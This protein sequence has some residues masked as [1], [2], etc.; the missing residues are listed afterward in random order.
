ME[1]GKRREGDTPK[2]AEDK[3]RQEGADYMV[4]EVGA[5]SIA[6]LQE[7]AIEAL[8]DIGPVCNWPMKKDTSLANHFNFCSIPPGLYERTLLFT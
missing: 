7:V 8:S 3:E 1:R 2:G 4:R 5:I 6:R